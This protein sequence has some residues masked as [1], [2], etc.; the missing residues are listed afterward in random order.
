MIARADV[1]SVSTPEIGKLVADKPVMVV[2]D[3]VELP[4][5]GPWARRWAAARRRRD[6]ARLASPL[7]IVWQG[8]RGNKV[9][10]SGMYSLTKLVPHLEALHS[11]L[12]LRLTVIGNSEDAFRSILGTARFPVRYVP[13]RRRTFARQ[14][15]AHDICVIPI[16]VNP[17]TICKSNNRPVLA[18]MLGLP[19]VADLIPSYAELQDFVTFAGDADGQWA[20]AIRSY[21]THA[22]LARQHVEDGQRYVRATYTPE[23]VVSQ[24]SQV[25]RAALRDS[26]R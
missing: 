21:A 17:F 5:F 15:A 18:L 3:A 12:P 11:E 26:P 20:S 22:D 9:P 16:D 7:R 6:H 23:R 25:L 2:D 14:F 4:P 24:W 10:R 1:V 8:Q 19:V 13:W